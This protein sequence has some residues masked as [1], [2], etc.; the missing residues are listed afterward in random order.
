[1]KRLLAIGDSIVEGHGV[2]LDGIFTRILGASIG[3]LGWEVV[4]AGVAGAS[5]IYYA[6]NIPRY[7]S[8]HPDAVLIMIFENDLADDRGAEVYFFSLPLMDDEDALLLGSGGKV[9]C[10]SSHI[11]AVLRRV[12]KDL[13]RVG[14][15]QIVARNQS[16]RPG[17]NEEQKAWNAVA[18]F[19]VA[20]SLIDQQWS[21]SE[22]YLDY[23]VE[24]FRSHGVLV[25]ITNICLGTLGPGLSDAYRIHC[26]QLN[27]KVA[28]W[29]KQRDVP[30]FS[31]L[32]IIAQSFKE[33]EPGELMIEDDGHPTRMTHALIESALRPWVVTHLNSV[34]RSRPR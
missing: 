26:W 30:F 14:V 12:W 13:H 1:L 22:A 33:H 23:V 24:S 17:I 32:P 8:L 19:L 20:P 5:P 6:A 3:S 21:M 25:L 10:C 28:A 15:S 31:L 34:G 4:N 2:E 29:A 27:G 11:Y 9:H 7:L 16:R 18:P